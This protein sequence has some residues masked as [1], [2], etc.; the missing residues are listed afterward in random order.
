MTV[1][2][3]RSGALVRLKIDLRTNFF[4]AKSCNDKLLERSQSLEVSDFHTRLRPV[5]RGVRHL[6]FHESSSFKSGEGAKE[7]GFSVCRNSVRATGG[8]TLNNKKRLPRTGVF[9]E[10]FF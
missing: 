4:E 2:A 5:F 8:V 1:R 3:T 9:R 6:S 7:W 10:L